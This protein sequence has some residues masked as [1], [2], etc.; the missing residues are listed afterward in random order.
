MEAWGD[1]A[2]IGIPFAT[3]IAAGFMAFPEAACVP[4]LLPAVLSCTLYVS[5]VLA[6]LSLDNGNSSWTI[7][8]TM[9]TIFLVAGLFCA[10]NSILTSGIP[11][12]GGPLT[13][14]ASSCAGRLRDLIDSIPYPSPSTAPLIKALL[15]GDRS[16]LDKDVIGI[17]R[18]SGAS[19]ILALSGLH[20]GI[21]YLILIRSAAP[22]G[23]GPAAR[24]LKYSLTIMASGFFVLMTGASSSIVRA[25]L[26]I[27]IN[28]T[29]KLLGR[30]RDPV[31][32][33]LAALTIQLALKPEVLTSLGFQLS[34]L[35]MA[36]IF[37]LYP[38]LERIY[39]ESGGRW[40]RFDPF[41]RIWKAAML[42]ISC[43]AFTAPL[44]WKRFHS[45]PRYFLITNL[46]ALPLTSAVMV[47]SVATIALFSLR[48]CP[49]LLVMLDDRAV[50]LLLYCLETI[51]SI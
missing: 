49:E 43:Q 26:F 10:S 30:E 39:P 6:A 50:Q 38:R 16:D 31:K 46:T 8:W 45:F 14:L 41:C 48:I 23:N 18:D 42:T 22:L 7:H 11:S 4:F 2:W 1:I 47:L 17:F 28:E 9:A 24:K 5:T 32:V 19:H 15:T 35:A 40:S 44:A 21:I 12:T 20:L 3:G 13:D 36:G 29:G 27:L 37:I 34:Y 51:S 33:L 25:F